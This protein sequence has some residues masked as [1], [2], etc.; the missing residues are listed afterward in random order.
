MWQTVITVLVV[1]LA[2]LWLGRRFWRKFRG[3]EPTCA[4][5]SGATCDLGRTCPQAG[6]DLK[7]S[8]AGQGQTCPECA[9]RASAKPA[10]AAENQ[11]EEEK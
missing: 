7:G 9:A 3:Q 8:A 1:V 4:C 6:P 11:R 10:A 5:D 2:I